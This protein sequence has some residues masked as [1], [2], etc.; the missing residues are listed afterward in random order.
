MLLHVL[1]FIFFGS[2]SEVGHEAHD[3]IL[4][5][6]IKE[7]KLDLFVVKKLPSDFS[8]VIANFIL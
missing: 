2:H 4:S 5:V 3:F 6:P 8:I 1:H 7:L